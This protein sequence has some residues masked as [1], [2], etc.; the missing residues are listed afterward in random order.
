MLVHH[1]FFLNSRWVKTMKHAV[2]LILAEHQTYSFGKAQTASEV[3]T[4]RFSTVSTPTPSS[5]ARWRQSPREAC[6]DRPCGRRQGTRS[7]WCSR[8][9]RCR[10][11]EASVS[12]H[13]GCC[14]TR[15]PKVR[16]RDTDVTGLSILC[17]LLFFG[18]VGVGGG[19]Q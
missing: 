12:T 6:W 7:W 10:P 18:G 13:T 16:T 14:T 9:W 8:T 17:R 2:L 4:A 19:G 3:S 1:L 15:V 5:S 11:T